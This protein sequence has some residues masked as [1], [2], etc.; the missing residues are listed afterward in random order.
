MLEKKIH[1]V[2]WYLRTFF[3][4]QLFLVKIDFDA[5]LPFRHFGKKKFSSFRDWLWPKKVS[6]VL[7]RTLWWK[8]KFFLW[9]FKKKKNAEVSF[10]FFKLWLFRKK[11]CTRPSTRAFFENSFKIRLFTCLQKIRILL[12]RKKRP[13]PRKTLQDSGPKKTSCKCWSRSCG[14]NLW[15]DIWAG[16]VSRCG[17]GVRCAGAGAVYVRARFCPHSGVWFLFCLVL[18]IPQEYFIT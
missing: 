5:I 8:E 2:K 15:G 1:P 16:A 6:F 14:E 13:A 18:Q 4:Y 12:G 11:T 17:C 7:N 9:S 3:V 10:F